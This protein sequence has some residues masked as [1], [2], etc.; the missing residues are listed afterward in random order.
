[1]RRDPVVQRVSDD[2]GGE[3]QV[4]PLFPVDSYPGPLLQHDAVPF[5]AIAMRGGKDCSLDVLDTATV[6]TEPPAIGTPWSERWTVRS[7]GKRALVLVHFVPDATGTTIKV[8]SGETQA[9]P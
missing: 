2:S 6:E 7:C 9:P 1:V 5:A 4:L 3:T 8:N